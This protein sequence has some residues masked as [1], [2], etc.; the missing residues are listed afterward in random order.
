MTL[1]QLTYFCLVARLLN[2]RKASEALH[3]SQSTISIA[4]S[5]L[6]SELGV[7]LFMREKKHITLTK[8]GTLY[9]QQITPILESLTSINIKMKQL[10]SETEGEISISYNPPWTYGLVPELARRFLF[11]K[12]NEKIKFKFTQLNSPRI[13]DGLKEGL[14]D[15]GFCTTE[16]DIPDIALFPIFTQEMA[17]IVPN[18]HPLSQHNSI[19]LSQI[20][21]Y[22]FILYDSESGLRKLV[23]HFLECSG[24]VPRTVYEAPNEEAI[25]ALVSAGFGISFVAITDALKKLEVK[26]I[27]VD[28]FPT[29]CTL[30][31]AYNTARYLPPAAVRFVKYIKQSCRDGIITELRRKI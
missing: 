6:E 20:G 14:F 26:M 8:Y 29:F 22:P 5:N 17:V 7:P 4:V 10:A 15:V 11:R 19:N 9:Y 27:K 1:Q 24:T 28:N 31:M 23:L 25:F 2:F 16:T 30:Y 13:I 18:G 12:E 21:N 3:I